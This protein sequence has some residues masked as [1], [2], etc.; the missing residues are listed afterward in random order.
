[1]TLVLAETYSWTAGFARVK[2]ELPHGTYVATLMDRN[3]LY[4][5]Q[6]GSSTGIYVAKNRSVVY[7]FS[8]KT[9][10]EEAEAARILRPGT[11]LVAKGIGLEPGVG[12]VDTQIIIR[13]DWRKAFK[14]ND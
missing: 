3:G 7:G 14:F 11:F 4:Y 10:E 6:E 9:P 2:H 12:K 8:L 1:M 13:G 5:V